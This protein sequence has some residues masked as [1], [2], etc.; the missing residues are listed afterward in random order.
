MEGGRALLG[1]P[2]GLEQAGK[3]G[4]GRLSGSNKL[5]RVASGKLDASHS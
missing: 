3:G 4:M 1:P 2:L 5:G